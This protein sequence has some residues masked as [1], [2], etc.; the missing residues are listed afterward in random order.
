MGML[1]H[2]LDPSHKKHDQNGPL[3]TI[4]R[5]YFDGDEETVTRSKDKLH[6]DQGINLFETKILD[7]FH[8][9]FAPLKS[10]VREWWK[11]LVHAY[12]F[13]G[14]EYY[15]I[16]DHIIRL[17]ETAISRLEEDPTSWAQKEDTDREVERRATLRENTRQELHKLRTGSAPL[18]DTDTTSPASPLPSATLQNSPASSAAPD[19]PTRRP[20]KRRRKLA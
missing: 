2:E 13:R 19:S 6:I 3:F 18:V 12:K 7:H 9:Y 11:T 14:N 20:V 15:H 1:R 10:L 16:H 17:L 5:E 8:P 4:V